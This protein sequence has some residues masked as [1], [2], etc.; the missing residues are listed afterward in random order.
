MGACAACVPALHMCL[1]FMGVC[2]ACDCAAGVPALHVCLCC[3][4][5]CAA[6]APALHVC[7]ACI[8]VKYAESIQLVF[9]GE[10]IREHAQPPLPK[11]LVGANISM[12]SVCG[13]T[14]SDA[15][16]ILIDRLRRS[17]S[18]TPGYVRACACVPGS[19]RVHLCCA[20]VRVAWCVRGCSLA[21]VSLAVLRRW[22]DGR[23][24]QVELPKSAFAS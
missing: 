2:A 6:W 1:R 16:F 12:F 17:G 4:G 15:V 22:D 18:G 19:A 7:A 13:H 21:F 10:I 20:R 24:F 3:M 5:A 8:Y 14:H 23:C 11:R 9:N